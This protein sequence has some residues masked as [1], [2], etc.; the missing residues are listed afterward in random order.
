MSGKVTSLVVVAALAASGAVAS[1]N[2]LANGGFELGTGSS[3]TSWQQAAVVPMR[4][5]DL[6]NARTGDA[7]MQFNTPLVSASV[8]LQNSVADGGGPDLSPGRGY[9]LSFRARGTIGSTGNINFSLRY[10]N[11]EGAIIYNSGASLIT[12][13]AISD[14]E[15]RQFGI[16]GIAFPA[17][18][19][20][21]FVEIVGANGGEGGPV[22]VRIDDVSVNVIPEPAALG[23]LAPLGLTLLRR[24]A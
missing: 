3:A 17:T 20:A 5:V 19:N 18:A 16:T 4:V 1:A 21:V 15:W 6:A 14:N 13:D 22:N 24:R 23:L 8:L 2:I 12:P 11:M 9:V 10:L 7:Y